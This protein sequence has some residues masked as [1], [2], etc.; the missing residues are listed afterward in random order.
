[1]RVKEFVYE[2]NGITYPVIVTKKRMKN[3]TYRFK[4]GTFYI[5]IPWYAFKNDYMKGLDKYADRLINSAKKSLARGEN[6]I[7]LLGEKVELNDSHQLVIPDGNIIVYKDETDMDKKLKK[8]FL[9]LVQE[10]VNYYQSLMGVEPYRVHVQKMTSRFGS[11]SK[12]TKSLNFSL[13]LMHYSID[14]I[15]SVVVHELAHILVYN[16][17]KQFYDVVY[18]YCPNYDECHHKLRKEIFQ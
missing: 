5:S 7:Y 18:R 12:H 9:K 6:Y 3:I 11:N 13:V 17:S 16:H 14:I 15:D 2:H 8:W 1:M 10:R 4:D